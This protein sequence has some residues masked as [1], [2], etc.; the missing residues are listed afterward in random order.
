MA[1]IAIEIKVD[2][3]ATHGYHWEYGSE[4]EARDIYPESMRNVYIVPK[5]S[6]IPENVALQI[7]CEHCRE[8]LG[9]R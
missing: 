8:V 5:D 3:G 7:T 6:E 2:L 4:A 9:L 1:V